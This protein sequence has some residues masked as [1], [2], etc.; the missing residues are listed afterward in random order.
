METP[1]KHKTHSELVR[2]GRTQSHRML[3]DGEKL[4][5]VRVREGLSQV[6]VAEYVSCKPATVCRWE[7]NKSRASDALILKLVELFHT[8][9]FVIWN[10][11]G[12][13]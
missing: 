7:Q 8:G 12:K 1:T 6:K 2:E 10:T 9:E 13:R 4:T 11:E 3:I 5:E